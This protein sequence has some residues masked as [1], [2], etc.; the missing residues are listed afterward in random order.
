M[1]ITV[2][3][4][5]GDAASVARRAPAP[6]GRARLLALL[7]NTEAPK[8]DQERHHPLLWNV[9]GRSQRPCHQYLGMVHVVLKV[10]CPQ[11]RP[12][13]VP[14]L[15]QTT[16]SAVLYEAFVDLVPSQ[17]LHLIEDSA[18]HVMSAGVDLLEGVADD[19]QALVK[20][21]GE[22]GQ[23]SRCRRRA[24]TRTRTLFPERRLATAL[25]PERFRSATAPIGKRS[26]SAQLFLERSS[27]TALFPERSPDSSARA[28]SPERSSVTA[29]LSPDQA[30]RSTATA[31]SLHVRT[32]RAR[33]Q[34]VLDAVKVNNRVYGGLQLIALPSMLA[35]AVVCLYAWLVLRVFSRNGP[36]DW[37][38][39]PTWIGV[40]G[41][42][43]VL[44]ILFICYIGEQAS[45]KYPLDYE[46]SPRL[47]HQLPRRF[48]A[49]LIHLAESSIKQEWLGFVFF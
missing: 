24:R 38:Y 16:A 26:S 18:I 46:C 28:L 25:F 23:P 5:R 15:G 17:L 43:T 12:T 44:K 13:A 49:I 10:V 19:V 20:A 47:R 1:L 11:Q 40:G 42:A 6:Q 22:T 2:K 45:T 37:T 7:P 36:A 39:G 41:I 3:N 32:L 33:Y 8:E 9:F 31:T 34:H 48:G 21:L 27:A 30:S 4:S 35:E 14:Q 29:L